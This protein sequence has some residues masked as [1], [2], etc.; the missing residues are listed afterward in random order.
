VIISEG[1][2]KREGTEGKGR[3]VERRGENR[4]E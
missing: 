3:G 4:R 1:E 2:S